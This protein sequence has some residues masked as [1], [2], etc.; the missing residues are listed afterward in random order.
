MKLE[1]NW[2][3]SFRGEVVQ[4]CLR[5]DDGRQV[6]TIAYPEPSAQVGSGRGEGEGMGWGKGAN[7]CLF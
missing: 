5:T 2:R 6:I 4:R 7:P 3:R 1:E